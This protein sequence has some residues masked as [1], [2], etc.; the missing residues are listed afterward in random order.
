MTTEYKAEKVY[1]AGTIPYIVEDGEVQMMFMKPSDPMYGGPD[2]QLAKGKI[3][4]GETAKEAALREAREE[5]GLFVGNVT[6][7]E[8][9]GVFM[10]RTTVFIAR[11]TSKDMFGMFGEE[12]GDVKWLTMEQFMTEGRILHQPVVQA[13]YRLICKAEGLPD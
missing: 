8:E 2:W 5:I 1:R 6:L 9:V 12:T 11:V 7:V 4:E 3:E 10:G 13:A